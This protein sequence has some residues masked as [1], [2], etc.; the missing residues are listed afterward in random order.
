MNLTDDHRRR[1]GSSRRNRS[2][3][4]SGGTSRQCYQTGF[5]TLFW[6]RSRQAESCVR[7]TGERD[8]K[9]IN[10][11]EIIHIINW[12]SMRLNVRCVSSYTCTLISVTALS[13]AQHS[14]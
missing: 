11:N 10:I 2:T 14:L 9:T 1:S 13:K 4:R 12:L 3:C 7:K 6:R 8:G 5:S